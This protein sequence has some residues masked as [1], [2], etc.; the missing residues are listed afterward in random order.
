MSLLKVV[1]DFEQAITSTEG[2]ACNLHFVKAKQ[3]W[4][5]RF[6]ARTNPS[7]KAERGRGVFV[8]GKTIEE[9]LAGAVAFIRKHGRPV[10]RTTHTLLRK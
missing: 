4:T 10:S 8:H 7:P 5:C 6:H 3:R 2:A 9:C 1:A